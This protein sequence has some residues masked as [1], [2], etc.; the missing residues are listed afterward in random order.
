MPAT[1]NE[2]SEFISIVRSSQPS[3]D[4]AVLIILSHGEL[5]VIFTSDSKRITLRTQVFDKFEGLIPNK[6]KLFIIQACRGAL[7]NL[8]CGHAEQSAVNRSR[9]SFKSQRNER[10]FT[11]IGRNIGRNFFKH[12]S[13][14]KHGSKFLQ[15]TDHIA[16]SQFRKPN[17]EYDSKKYTPKPMRSDMFIWYSTIADYVSIRCASS[18]TVFI[19][20]LVS[21]LSKAG[22]CYELSQLSEC[23]NRV[24]N[25]K[26]ESMLNYEESCY[27]LRNVDFHRVEMPASQ[28]PNNDDDH[29][30]Q[31][32]CSEN[33]LMKALYFNPGFFI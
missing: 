3:P 23:V 13:K 15:E 27:S 32:P 30:A 14:S 1:I 16:G 26:I 22:W 12:S 33:Y 7:K 6:P 25:N 31:T 28:H 10:I 24:I 8:I 20:T 5:D 17:I 19:N 2:I 29:P 9:T 18:G 4:A 21:V 11:L